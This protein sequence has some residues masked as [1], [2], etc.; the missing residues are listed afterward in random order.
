MGSGDGRNDNT[1]LGLDSWGSRK[2]GGGFKR[3]HA[4]VIAL[5]E[6]ISSLPLRCFYSLSRAEEE[7]QISEESLD[8]IT[9]IL[10]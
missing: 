7:K 9:W 8:V 10:Y 6:S 2:G 4:H 1:L 5:S 3:G